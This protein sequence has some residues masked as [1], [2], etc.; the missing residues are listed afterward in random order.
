MPAYEVYKAW[1]QSS[2]S[3]AVKRVYSWKY[4]MYT[5]CNNEKLRSDKTY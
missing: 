5:I 1:N 3:E 4:S 2:C